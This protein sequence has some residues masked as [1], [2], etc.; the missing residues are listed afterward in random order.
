MPERREIKV[1]PDKVQAA[2][3]Q[4]GSKGWK[5]VSQN[6]QGNQVVLIFER[7]NEDFFAEPATPKPPKK[8]LYKRPLIWIP[9]VL[10]IACCGGLC[11]ISLLFAPSDEELAA[12][13]TIEAQAEIEENTKEA[14]ESATEVAVQNMT[15]TIIALTPTATFTATIPPTN[16]LP[17]T[18]TPLPTNTLAVQPASGKR[19]INTQMINVRACPTTACEVLGTLELNDAVDLKGQSSGW[20]QISFR[21]GDG[22]IS[23]ELLNTSPIAPPTEPPQGFNEEVVLELIKLTMF[24]EDVPINSISLDG[25]TL[26]VTAPFTHSGFDDVLTYQISVIGVLSGATVTIFQDPNTEIDPPRTIRVDFEGINAVRFSYTDAASFINGEI[27]AEE[28]IGRLRD[29]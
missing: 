29:E 18:Q 19:Y 21:D 11:I 10:F 1:A 9:S 2:I 8:P 23:G 6:P 28:F 12:T 3:Q 22:W 14:V 4:G 24:T 27:S 26:E 17:P 25:D 20:F 7:D 5:L 15:A 13:R 16:T